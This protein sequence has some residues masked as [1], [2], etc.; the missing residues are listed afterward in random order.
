MVAYATWIRDILTPERINAV[1]AQ[2][3]SSGYEKPPC[4]GILNR[5]VDVTKG[6]IARTGTG[7]ATRREQ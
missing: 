3:R 1:S 4:P 7:S 5:Y 6:G 2:A